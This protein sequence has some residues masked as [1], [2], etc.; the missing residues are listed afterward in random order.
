MVQ[1]NGDFQ[2]M[3]FQY[4]DFS[5]IYFNTLYKHLYEERE[6]L[7]ILYKKIFFLYILARSIYDDLSSGDAAGF[8]DDEYGKAE[9]SSGGS[10]SR[11]ESAHKSDKDK[12][13]KDKEKEDR[14]E[15]MR[16]EKSH[17]NILLFILQRNK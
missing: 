12:D 7:S 10:H 2:Q 3:N 11:S 15:G 16:K 14:D 4:F 8:R 13:R 9:T 5:R 17:K 1:K 6:Y